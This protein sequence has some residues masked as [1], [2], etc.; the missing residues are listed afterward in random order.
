M[1][2]VMPIRPRETITPM[3]IT[4]G[5]PPVIVV[6]T[7]AVMLWCALA[8][9]QE[10]PVVF[11]HGI[12]SSGNTWRDAANRLQAA[13]DLHA[14]TPDLS[15]GAL[16]EVQAE[17]LATRAGAVGDDVVAIGH[18]NGGLVARQWSVA[19]PVSALVTVGTPHHGVP[20]V[21][22]FASLAKLNLQLLSSISDVYRLFGSHC[23]NWQSLL[24]SYSLWWNLVYDI[25]SSS[26]G[27]IARTL[28]VAAAEP[29]L[30][31][32]VPGSTYLS[33]LN[34]PV[35][36]V[37]ESIEVPTRVGIVSTAHNFYWGGILRAAIPD[38][39]DEL[40]SWRDI[41]RVG[42]DFAAAYLLSNADF[43]DWGAFEIAD[44]LMWCSN[45]LASMD[46]WWCQSVSVTGFGECWANDT[47]VPEW[48]QVFPNGLPIYTGFD[49]P[50]HS[51][52][53][54]MSDALLHTVLT[55]YTSIPPRASGPAPVSEP[56]VIDAMFH[57]DIEF[58]GDTLTLPADLAFVGP[59]W[60]DR[61]S[62][63]HVPDGRTVVL[64]EHAEF[65]GESLTLSGDA[66]DLRMFPGPALDGTWNDAASSI[67]VF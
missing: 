5:R 66:I 31:E 49:G 3:I 39:G 16:Y 65:G 15:A 63:V 22:N 23:C 26:F 56:P 60:N 41:A 18:S 52:E 46:E 37:R 20:V 6:A 59:E 9:A 40:A 32:M 29:V 62:S 55:T 36:L 50:A 28:G 21:P 13:L 35:N 12:A 10:R 33:G 2:L 48:S 53:T 61:I 67:R 54:H 8:S 43:G 7:A 34:S 51:Q 38:H 11:V 47:L 45:I 44:G 30:T 19:R 58:Q 14:E 25:S 27:Q 4:R 24:T 42:M 17:Q 57:S 1:T 64:Y